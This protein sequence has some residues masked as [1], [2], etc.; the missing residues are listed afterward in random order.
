MYK[1]SL[2]NCNY[3]QKIR[4]FHG[5]ANGSILNGETNMIFLLDI[6]TSLYEIPEVYKAS[7]KT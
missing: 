7:R 6:V 2:K 5:V 4:F 1:I 3:N